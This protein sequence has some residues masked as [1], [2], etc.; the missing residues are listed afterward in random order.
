[1]IPYE[2]LL[3]L[4]IF[5]QDHGMDLDLVHLT[6]ALNQHLMHPV[7][8]FRLEINGKRKEIYVLEIWCPISKKGR[9]N[10]SQN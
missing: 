9:K 7:V 8:V 5:R 10:S 1:M 6:P 3:K 4:H 2:C